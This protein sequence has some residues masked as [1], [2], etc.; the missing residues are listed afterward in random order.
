MLLYV[1]LVLLV[2][3]LEKFILM[4]SSWKYDGLLFV[5]FSEKCDD[6]VD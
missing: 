1:V 4:E 5:L 6:F 3:S 2:A